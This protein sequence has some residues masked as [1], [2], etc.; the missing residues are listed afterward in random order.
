MMDLN[1]ESAILCRCSD[2]DLKEIRRL[3]EAGYT[4]IDDLKR[5]ARLGMGVCQGRNC[6]PL[7]LQEL[8]KATGKPVSELDPSTHRPVVKS[9]AL[10]A[11]A[12]SIER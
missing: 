3:I 12:D 5:V 10:G 7:A 4:S 11:V 2:L 9:V 1:E 6:I 8:S